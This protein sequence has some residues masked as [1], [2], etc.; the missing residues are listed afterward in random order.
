M[1]HVLTVT[2]ERINVSQSI[3]LNAF[4]KYVYILGYCYYWLKF[5]LL[6]YIVQWE[7][8]RNLGNI[9]KRALAYL[10]TSKHKVELSPLSLLA[11]VTD[12]SD[13]TDIL[14]RYMK[15]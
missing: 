3:I 11:V 7:I 4:N 5:R 14:P 9:D 10:W 13:W 12:M 2:R 8:Q 15:K 6:A 1:F